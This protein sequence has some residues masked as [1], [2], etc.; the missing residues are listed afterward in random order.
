VPAAPSAPLLRV[1]QSRSRS[2]AGRRRRAHGSRLIPSSGWAG[3]GPVPARVEKRGRPVHRDHRQSLTWPRSIAAGQRTIRGTRSPPSIAVPLL[4][5][6]RPQ[7]REPFAAVVGCRT[8]PSCP[9]GNRG[10]PARPEPSRHGV[11]RLHHDPIG[12]QGPAFEMEQ[13]PQGVRPRGPRHLHTGLDVRGTFPWPVRRGVFSCR[14]EG[15]SPIL[16]A[17]EIG[18]A[19]PLRI[20]VVVTD[21]L[22]RH[23]A[24][25]RGLAARRWP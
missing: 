2:G 25:V 19:G 22:N 20:S 11:Q 16:M 8:R 13:R 15:R 10:H 6:E 17:D 9:L 21:L 24:L 7:E 23:L 5:D 1:R 4:P 3:A 18:G 14:L 12:H